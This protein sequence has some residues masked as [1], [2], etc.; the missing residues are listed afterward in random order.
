MT[1]VIISLKTM[2]CAT[3]IRNI[4]SP[5][6][7]HSVFPPEWYRKQEVALGKAVAGNKRVEKER[8]QN[9]VMLRLK[10]PSGCQLA[11]RH[12]RRTR[13]GF[14]AP[15]VKQLRVSRRLY[16]EFRIKMLQRLSL[17]PPSSRKCAGANPSNW[18]KGE[19]PERLRH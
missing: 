13:N 12:E 15:W 19:R 18:V 9:L 5:F 4:T 14:L 17:V 16:L 8:Q 11:G 2:R 1:L 3:V 6:H 7:F 10:S